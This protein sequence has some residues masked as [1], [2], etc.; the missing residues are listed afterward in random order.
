MIGRRSVPRDD[1]DR[2]RI[3]RYGMARLGKRFDGNSGGSRGRSDQLHEVSFGQKPRARTAQHDASRF[4]QLDGKSIEVGVL[5]RPLFDLTAI[6]NQFGGVENHDIVL[7]PNSK[8]VTHEAKAS[9]C[10]MNLT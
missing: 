8:H 5:S 4:H 9:D 2:S 6:P 1:L 10:T 7:P 3:S